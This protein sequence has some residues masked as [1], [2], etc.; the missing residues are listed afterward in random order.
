MEII[1][2]LIRFCASFGY[3]IAQS[4]PSIYISAAIF[5]PRHSRIASL[6]SKEFPIPPTLA[7]VTEI[8][9][10]PALLTLNGHTSGVMSV[11]FSHDG[12]KILSRTYDQTILWGAESASL[13]LP[14]L[15]NS[16]PSWGANAP[17]LSLRSTFSRDGWIVDSYNCGFQRISVATLMPVPCMR[18][19]LS[20]SIQNGFRSLSMDLIFHGGLELA[21]YNVHHWLSV[22]RGSFISL[23]HSLIAQVLHS[24]SHMIS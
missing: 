22:S 11:A 24:Q 2:D 8:L 6:S 23:C 10:D 20:F 17:S 1:Q 15:A 18:L 16:V 14:S 19:T 4:A 13:V 9:W 21:L 12:K 3:V 7:S 5:T